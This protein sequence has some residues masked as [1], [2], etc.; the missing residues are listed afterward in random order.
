MMSKKWL[1]GSAIPAGL[2]VLVAFVFF[3]SWQNDETRFIKAVQDGD[4]NTVGAMLSRNSELAGSELRY[5]GKGGT[6]SVLYIAI[7]NDHREIVKLLVSHVDP[8]RYCDAL[9][10]AHNT[11][12]VGLLIEQGIDVNGRGVNGETVL[13]SRAS[14]DNAVMAEFVINH[15]ADVNA[16][17]NRGLTPLHHAAQEGCL[18]AAKLLVSKGAD[19]TAKSKENKTP[20]DYAVFPV[21]DE[22]ACRVEQKRIHRC[23]EVAAYLLECGSPCAI[24][25]LAWLGDMKRMAEMLKTD[26]ALVNAQ[27]NGE[28]VLFSAIRGGN[29][30]VVEYLLT[31]SAQLKVTGRFRQS[32]L[33]LAAYMGYADV[34]RVLLNHGANVNEKGP[35]GETA[36]HWAA[37]NG[38]TEVAALL[39]ERGADPNSRT[40]SHTFELN[41]RAENSDP[42]EREIKWFQ[43]L[44]YQRR[45]ENV[46][47]ALPAR[48][49]FT[50]DDMPI[51]AATYWNHVDIV[52]LLIDNGADI[53]RANCWGATP[54]HYAVVCRYHDI[55]KVLLDNGADP[56]AKTHSGMMPVDIA[57]KVKDEDLTNLLTDRK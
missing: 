34:A 28:S 47:V 9:W 8:K 42:V 19:L 36:L 2:V 18:N 39:L 11:E 20:F 31:H 26:P 52:R 12:M 49:A 54:L 57:R 55:V 13:H 16:R 21:W 56:K 38:N 35:W 1:A 48:M 43:T 7:S 24:F 10:F 53:N 41:V 15:G 17:D 30:E 4:V 45:S 33:Q 14:M 6:I 32:P 3:F 27:A 5:G 46:Q 23:K 37:V 44:E 29:A 22:D 51:H 40:S 50:K 25:D